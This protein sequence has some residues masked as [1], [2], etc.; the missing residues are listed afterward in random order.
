[1]GSCKDVNLKDKPMP[2]FQN[3][4]GEPVG[5]EVSLHQAKLVSLA[6]GGDG[7]SPCCALF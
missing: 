6:R 5:F 1:M 4:H 3:R 7:I 2:S